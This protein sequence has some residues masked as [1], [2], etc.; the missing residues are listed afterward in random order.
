LELGLRIQEVLKQPQYQPL[1]VDQQV[2]ILYAV[3]N[4]FLDEVPVNKVQEW[5][6]QF[7]S[8]MT[9]AHPEIGQAILTEKRLDDPLIAQLKTAIEEFQRTTTV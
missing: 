5:E 1:R 3:T 9:N 6:A 4:G 7:H 8:F 2:M